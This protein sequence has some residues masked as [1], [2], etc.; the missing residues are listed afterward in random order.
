VISD[1]VSGE[2][3]KTVTLVSTVVTSER[4]EQG[5]YCV[6]APKI[7]VKYSENY[8]SMGTSQMY[9]VYRITKENAKYSLLR[10]PIR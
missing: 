3:S 4:E 6:A 10:I 7:G 1:L 2:N 9:K 5:L 8:Y